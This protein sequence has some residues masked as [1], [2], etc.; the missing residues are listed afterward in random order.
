MSSFLD[1]IQPA[2]KKETRRVAIS[3]I[4]GVVLMWI[5]FAVL[6][7]VI[8]EKVPFDHTVIL[9]GIGG[10][11]IAVLNFFLMGMTV[12][13][14]ASE[15][16][17]DRAK[18]WMKTELLMPQAL[19]RMNLLVFSKNWKR[20]LKASLLFFINLFFLISSFKCNK[21]NIYFRKG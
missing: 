17:E 3:T 7:L 11:I 18:M 10:G 6:H 14:I 20:C 12:Q 15:T 2:V 21:K 19:S 9:G 8:P 1:N 4:T 13:K 5:A 16:D